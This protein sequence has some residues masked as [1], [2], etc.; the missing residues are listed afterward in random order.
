V[1]IEA[2]LPYLDLDIV[3]SAAERIETHERGDD[4]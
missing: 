1:R 3:P 4:R 2:L